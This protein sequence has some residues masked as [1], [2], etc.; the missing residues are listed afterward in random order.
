MWQHVSTDGWHLRGVPDL[1]R[2]LSPGP[3]PHAPVLDGPAGRLACR[4]THLAC[5][6]RACHSKN[7]QL[8]SGLDR[9]TLLAACMRASVSLR[10]KITVPPCTARLS[11]PAQGPA[12]NKWELQP[13]VCVNLRPEHG[14][15]EDEGLV[16]RMYA[17]IKHGNPNPPLVHRVSRYRPRH[18]TSHCIL[19]TLLARPAREGGGPPCACCSSCLAATNY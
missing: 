12:L 9:R 17:C 13:P 6:A 4:T 11:S 8:P 5:A 14:S 7:S 10:N 2:K 19:H 3:L 1:R 16:R 15:S 18:E